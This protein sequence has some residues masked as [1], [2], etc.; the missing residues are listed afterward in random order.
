[1]LSND[2]AALAK[3]T[4]R[5]WAEIVFLTHADMSEAEFLE[6]VRQWLKTATH[7]R[8]KRLYTDLVYQP[9]R[10]V[11]DYL[12]GNGFKVF[13][14]TGGVKI[15]SA[16]TPTASMVFSLSKSSAQAL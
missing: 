2:P 10:E 16:P 5:D 8:F 4:E 11:M 9:M 14:V 12:R 13:I 6:L 3:F 15:S 1:V 7:P